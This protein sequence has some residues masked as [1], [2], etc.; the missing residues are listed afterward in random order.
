M[1]KVKLFLLILVVCSYSLTVFADNSLWS[2]QAVNL[3]QDE[4]KNREFR[5]GDV[6]TIIIEEDANAVQSANTN[7]SQESSIDAGSGLGIFDF[8]KAFGF[9]YSDQSTA[10][11]KTVQS[12]K[13]KADITTIIKEVLPSGNFRIAGTKEI[14]INGEEQIIRLSG[15]IRPEDITPE[16]T[17]S[18]KKVAEASIDYQGKGVV[19]DKQKPGLLERLLNWIF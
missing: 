9:S 6:V 11:G 13:L 2:D 7:T 14:K 10:D 5:V 8:I 16:N 18:S 4:D 12:G 3:Y 19:A 1:V 17:V 15:I